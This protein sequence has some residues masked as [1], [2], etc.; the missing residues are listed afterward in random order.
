MHN[1]AKTVKEYMASLPEDRRGDI[2]TVRKI[3]L[4]NLPEGFEEFMTYGMIGYGIPLS[5]YPN[6]YNGQPI[7]PA[8]LAMQKNKNSIYLMGVY[9]NKEIEQWFKDAYKKS[10]KKLDM[11]KSCVR[12]KKAS[13][14]PLDVIGK[15]IAR[16]SVDDFIRNYE[17][18]LDSRGKRTKGSG[19]RSTK[20]QTKD[21]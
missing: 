17:Q 10:G 13:D 3:I 20:K 8:A 21:K 7:G 18:S 16:V 6:T 11:G 19:V 1:P 4:D 15:V 14:L 2:E 5:R 12:F 9:G